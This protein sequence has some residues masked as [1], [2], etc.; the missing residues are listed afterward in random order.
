[1]RTGK[2]PE[3]ALNRSVLKQVHTGN[4]RISHPFSGK[5]LENTKGAAIGSDCAFFAASSG[6]VL[7][8]CAQEAAVAG[9]AGAGKAAELVQKCANNLAASGTHP[10]SAQISIMLPEE[11][12]EA[13]VK[14]LMEEITTACVSLGM[15]IAGGDTNVTDAVTQPILTITAIGVAK[16]GE[17]P[18]LAKA[19]PGQALV[20]SKWIGLEGTAVLTESFREKLLERYPA[21]LVDEAA[22]FGKYLSIEKEAKIATKAGV[23]AMHDLSMGGVFGG[24]W[25]LA[26][27][28]GLGLEV[29]LKKIPIRQE[30]VEVCEVCGVNPYEMRSGGS[31]LMA[32]EDGEALAAALEAEGIPAAV[33]G[34]LTGKQD[35]ILLNEEEIRFLD[36]PRGTD[37]IAEKLRESR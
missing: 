1:M 16:A 29:D 27:G 28:A 22:G 12:E 20:L 36:R 15:E 2:L 9:K 11:C 33:I 18:S 3:S 26:E 35:R 37:V 17:I 6:Q 10:A 34:R 25:E 31:L 23:A 13:L 4:H 30:T 19:K 21:Y 8:W 24:L 14:E 7:A 5:I 32:T